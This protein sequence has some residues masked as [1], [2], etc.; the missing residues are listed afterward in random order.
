MIKT[1]QNKL[2]DNSVVVFRGEGRWGKN[3]E[4]KGVKHMAR[5]ED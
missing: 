4:G 2:I 5:E 1:K 3:K